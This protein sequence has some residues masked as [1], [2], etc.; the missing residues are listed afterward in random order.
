MRIC[1]LL[2]VAYHLSCAKLTEFKNRNATFIR[3]AI[4]CCKFELDGTFV[5]RSISAK[6][7]HKHNRTVMDMSAKNF[8]MNYLDNIRSR[9]FSS[10]LCKLKMVLLLADEMERN[11]TLGPDYKEK[12]KLDSKQ[13]SDSAFG[14]HLSF[15]QK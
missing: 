12:D 3:H 1:Y 6:L 2:F 13:I 10:G 14:A 7:V 8:L 11:R 9:I 5:W 4:C 15:C